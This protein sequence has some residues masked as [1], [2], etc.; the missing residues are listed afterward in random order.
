MRHFLAFP[1][2]ADSL[3]AEQPI[4]IRDPWSG[5]RIFAEDYYSGGEICFNSRVT[6]DRL[7]SCDGGSTPKEHVTRSEN[8]NVNGIDSVDGDSPKDLH[9]ISTD[10]CLCLVSRLLRTLTLLL[11]VPATSCDRRLTPF[12]V[13]KRDS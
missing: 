6:A 9:S 7:G 8:E 3:N 12:G 11:S 2:R 13:F 10:T 5:P 1:P 4:E